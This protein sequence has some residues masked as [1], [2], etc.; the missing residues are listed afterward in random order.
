[1]KAK[2]APS[3]MCADIMNMKQVLEVFEK[4]IAEFLGI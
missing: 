1:M 2:I 4:N 3:M